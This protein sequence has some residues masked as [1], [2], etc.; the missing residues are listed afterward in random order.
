[1]ASDVNVIEVPPITKVRPF[2]NPRPHTSM[3]AAMIRFLD[4]VKSTLF[5][6]MFLTPM[7]EIIPYRMKLT[8]PMIAEG[9]EPMMADILGMKLS[10]IA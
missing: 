6:T 10:K 4:L 2:E 8:P 9:S 7:A 3:T 5:S 1:M